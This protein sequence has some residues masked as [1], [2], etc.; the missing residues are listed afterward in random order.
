[1][2]RPN[3]VGE[4]QLHK[5]ASSCA[6][7][8]YSQQCESSEIRSDVQAKRID[9]RICVRHTHTK[10]RLSSPVTDLDRPRG[11]QEVKV[12]RFRDNGTGW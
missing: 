8:C 5:N 4:R 1:M 2:R 3:A 12:P 11:F 10:K 9:A 7:V 6:A